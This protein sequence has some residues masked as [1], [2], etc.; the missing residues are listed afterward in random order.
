MVDI[1]KML[2]DQQIYYNYRA[3]DWDQWIRHYM[4]PV[5]DEIDQLMCDS[6]L[7]GDVLDMACGTGFWTT[8]L[9]GI[10]N[11]VT[12]VDGSVEM[13]KKVRS[14]ELG[15]VDTIHADLFSWNPPTQWDA[16]FFAHWLAHVPDARFDKFWSI[17]DAALLPDGYVAIV[18]VTS[19]EKRIEENLRDDYSWPVT[20]RRLKDGR[21][22]DV[23]K[24]YWDPD[25]LM[26]RLNNIGWIGTVTLVGAD[27][28]Y[29]FVYYLLR[30]SNNE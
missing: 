28:G 30:R 6:P 14:R 1:D 26:E 3:Q 24:K 23:I 15:N 7:R 4:R 13:L 27:R 25:D 16:V 20:R 29:G 5:Q 8:R 19:I 22:F 17:V 18:D 2:I 12:A 9:A 21:K 11:S 10:A